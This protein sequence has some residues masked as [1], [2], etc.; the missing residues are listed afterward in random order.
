MADTRCSRWRFTRLVISERRTSSAF[1]KSCDSHP[2]PRVHS[3]QM[4]R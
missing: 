3:S 4:P 1:I 2:R